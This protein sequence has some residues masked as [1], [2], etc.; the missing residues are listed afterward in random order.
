M[1]ALFESYTKIVDRLCMVILWFAGTGL[2]LMTVFVSWQVF[3]RFVLN[4]TPTWTEPASLMLMLWFILLAAAVGVRQRFH[5]SL[6]LFRQIVPEPVRMAMDGICFVAVGGFGVGMLWYT[7]ILISQ[8][9]SVAIPGLGLP[10]G[11]SYLPI[12]LSG[13]LIVLFS[14]EQLLRLFLAARGAARQAEAAPPAIVQ[15]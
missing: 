15:E 5:L 12:S 7:H 4:D 8:T 3:G 14:I 13:G 1:L 11:L 6:D 2:F 10:V 9:W